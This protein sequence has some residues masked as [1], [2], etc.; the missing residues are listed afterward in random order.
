VDE[1]GLGLCQV[2]GFGIS[3]IEPSD[4]SARV[5][6]SVRWVDVL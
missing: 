1:T 4:S 5:N 3:S 2:L 6:Q